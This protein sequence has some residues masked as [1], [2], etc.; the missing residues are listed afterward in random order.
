M[1]LLSVP[2]ATDSIVHGDKSPAVLGQGRSGSGHSLQQVGRTI[3]RVRGCRS[4][5]TDR[6]DGLTAI[7]GEVD[8][9]SE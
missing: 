3:G 7:D 8:W 6:N 4:H 9:L 1:R 2:R 5:G